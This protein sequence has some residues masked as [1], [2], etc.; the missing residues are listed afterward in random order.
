MFKWISWKVFLLIV[1][2]GA[3]GA[4]G[5]DE[6][7]L[8]K[9]ARLFKIYKDYNESP[10]SESS[11][12]MALQ[13][14]KSQSYLIQKGDTLWDISNTFFADPQF[15]PKI[16]SLNSSDIFNPHEISPKNEVLFVPGSMLEPPQV[17]VQAK[18]ETP[19]EEPVVEEGAP[20]KPK[21]DISYELPAP[22]KRIM[23]LNSF[24][25]SLPFWSHAREKKTKLTMDF[26]DRSRNFPAP[27][28]AMTYFV[29]DRAPEPEGTIV[30]TELNLG[31]AAEYQYIYVKM[32][33]E[34]TV[35][36]DVLV[37][38]SNSKVVDKYN[39]RSAQ[40]VE[41]QGV[42]QV[43]ELVN[44]ED[45]IYRAM[46]KKNLSQ[47]TVG[48]KVMTAEVPTL[49]AQPTGEPTTFPTRIIGGQFSDRRI[50]YSHDTVVFLNA[51]QVQGLSVGQMLPIYKIPQS[52][53]PKTYARTNALRI[54]EMK[55]VKVSDNFATAIV[56][57]STE[58]I[59]T[60]DSASPDMYTKAKE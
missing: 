13:A 35:P 59:R 21:E 20:E 25:E 51:G 3:V 55:V 58:D 19:T 31:A 1:I 30:E 50:M 14:S 45:K 42:V 7:D 24:P 27:E 34:V 43:L 46:V 53:T 44:S 60:G 40:L 49:N 54:G 16:W 37:F 57:K 48:A 15:W 28:M 36:K 29:D 11:W 22:L 32:K 18:T 10:T 8:A 52:R 6:P 26:E 23:P 41:I 56:V 47:V 2:S 38:V 17:A 39:N 9:E 4:Q 33:E 12:Q 5:T